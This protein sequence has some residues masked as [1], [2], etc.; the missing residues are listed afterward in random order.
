M[1]TIYNIY[2]RI[3]NMPNPSPG[4]LAFFKKNPYGQIWA[5]K[6]TYLRSD[7]ISLKK[8]KSMPL[9][10]LSIEVGSPF[11]SAYRRGKKTDESAIKGR[12]FTGESLRSQMFTG[13]KK[14]MRTIINLGHKS[15]P[16]WFIDITERVVE[17]LLTQGACALSSSHCEFKK[18]SP[19][20]KEC[21]FCKRKLHAKVQVTKK[22]VWESK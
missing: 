21:Q 5:Y 19:K 4:L 15:A 3:K 1:S 7:R 10:D 2:Q 9:E 12:V 11:G 14:R 13:R 16:L 18:T 6:D 17:L 20:V 22:I 8:L